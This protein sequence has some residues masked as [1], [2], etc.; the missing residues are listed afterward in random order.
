M[1]KSCISEL[2]K[3]SGRGFESQGTKY[4]T[5]PCMTSN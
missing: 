4:H 5:L 2:N 3:G 1:S